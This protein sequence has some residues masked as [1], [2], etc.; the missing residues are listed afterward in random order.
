MSPPGSAATPTWMARRRV[1]LAGRA[2]F[3][4]PD[5]RIISNDV[6]LVVNKE[7]DDIGAIL[8]LPLPPHSTPFT[9]FLSRCPSLNDDDHRAPAGAGAVAGMLRWITGNLRV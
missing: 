2:V 4:F 8:S 6:G 1:L 9:A 7:N 5:N 3:A